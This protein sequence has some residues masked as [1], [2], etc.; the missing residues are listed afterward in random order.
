MTKVHGKRYAYKF[1][2]HGLMAAC[3]AQAQGG[4]S[5]GMI[6]AAANYSKY[7]V[8]EP[9]PIYNPAIPSTS[10]VS[11]TSVA[12]P[13]FSTPYWPYSPPSFDPRPPPSF[14]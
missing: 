7:H 9:H 4:D 10:K 12:P 2:F 11:S 13:L 8:H 14:Q 6:T 1:D 5:T 3:Q